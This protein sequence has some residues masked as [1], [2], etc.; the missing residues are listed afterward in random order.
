M[1]SGE[2]RMFDA[3]VV[4]LLLLFAESLF[5]AEAQGFVQPQGCDYFTGYLLHFE[6]LDAKKLATPI[7]LKFPQSYFWD[8]MVDQKDP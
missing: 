3:R 4:L 1:P 7:V 5:A 8:N 6:E 2:W